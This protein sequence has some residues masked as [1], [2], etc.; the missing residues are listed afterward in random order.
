MGVAAQFGAACALALVLASRPAAPAPSAQAPT[1]PVPAPTVG[2]QTTHPTVDCARLVAGLSLRDQLAQRLMVGVDPTDPRAAR[3]LVG[4]THV[5]GVFIP[6][7]ATTIL[8]PSALAAVRSGA[9]VPVAIAVDEEG[10]RVQRIDRL[11]GS[12]PSARV[13]GRMP[14]DEVRWIGERRG[15]QLRALGITMD[16]APVLDTSAQPDGG[17]IGDRSFSADPE[18]VATHASAFA[19]GLRAAGIMPAF[20]HFPG[21]GRAVGD[22]HLGVATTPDLAALRS[23]DLKPYGEV[24]GR[25][26]AAVMVGHLD[27]PGLTQGLP[28]TLSPAAYRL[29][30]GDLHFSGVI[31]TDD[32]G[33]M[34]AVTDRFGLVDAVTRALEAHADIALWTSAQH[35][36]DVLDHLEAETAA[37]RLPVAD[38]DAAVTRIVTMKGVC[39]P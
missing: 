16:L 17:V 34:R 31:L 26:A 5:G 10:G 36:D 4:R 39:Q 14:V 21:H 32:L 9:P 2:A 11:D 37:G 28:A 15:E 6:G 35:V 20:K 24:L 13:M 38:T 19:S 12:M 7:N 22:S 3:D 27:V 30:R 29:L 23:V 25:G 1:V 8:T 18:V 33:A